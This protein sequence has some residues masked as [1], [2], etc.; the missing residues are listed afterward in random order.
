[1]RKN[2]TV[3]QMAETRWFYTFAEPNTKGETLVIELSKCTNWGG[4]NALP[5]LWKKHGHIDRVLETH[6]S[7]STYVRDTE[8]NC[9]GMYNPQEKIREDGK[10]MVINFDWMF[11]ATEENKERLIDEVFRIFSLQKGKTARE[12]KKEKIV[13][14]AKENNIKL[15]DSIPEG[16]F[17]LGYG[18]APFGSRWIGNYK[19]F[20]QQN[21]QKGLLIL[22]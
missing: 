10:A 3:E 2:Y 19:S 22:A 13:E 15:Y 11:E 16:W 5:V 18:T 4:S 17:D 1:M 21:K 6:W 12:I 14:Y 9:Y 7:I 8:G 20:K